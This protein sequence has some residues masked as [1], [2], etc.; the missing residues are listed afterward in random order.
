MYV[1]DTGG[2]LASQDPGIPFVREPGAEKNKKRGIFAPV[3]VNSGKPQN[4]AREHGGIVPDHFL[5]FPFTDGIGIA[6]VRWTLFIQQVVRILIEFAGGQGTGEYEAFDVQ[7]LC[8]FEHIPGTINIG[9][10]VLGIVIHCEIIIPCQVQDE[11]CP[12]IPVNALN[13][14]LQVGEIPNINLGPA[15]VLMFGYAR[16]LLRS[17]G[18]AKK[19]VPVG[20]LFDKML[21]DKT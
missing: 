19:P 6:G 14:F 21:P 11:I 10:F 7:V 2:S 20:I 4:S 12:P 3:T 17:S 16:F 13:Y 9:M 18:Q 5:R 1:G 15:N 8:Q